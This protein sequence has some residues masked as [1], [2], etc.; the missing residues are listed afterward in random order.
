[1]FQCVAND[2]YHNITKASKAHA[3]NCRSNRI[4]NVVSFIVENI[5]QLVFVIVSIHALNK[6]ANLVKVKHDQSSSR[7]SQGGF[8]IPGSE[9]GRSILHGL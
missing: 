7:P 4:A 2:Y 3:T 9:D 6:D 5:K 1:L 8:F